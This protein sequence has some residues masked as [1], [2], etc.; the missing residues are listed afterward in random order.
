MYDILKEKR[1]NYESNNDQIE[2]FRI[3]LYHQKF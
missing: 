3:L 2:K 1:R